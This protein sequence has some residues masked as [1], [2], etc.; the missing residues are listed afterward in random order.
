MGS[1]M[2][3][4]CNAN[5]NSD[6]SDVIITIIVLRVKEKVPNYKDLSPPLLNYINSSN[7]E[8]YARFINFI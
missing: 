7:I 6:N 2:Q 8:S 3:A 1:Q 4:K 5:S